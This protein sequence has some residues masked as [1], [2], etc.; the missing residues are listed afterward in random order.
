MIKEGDKEIYKGRWWVPNTQKK[1]FGVLTIIPNKEI[2]LELEGNLEL[3]SKD[4][5]ILYDYLPIEEIILG[6]TNCGRKITLY[7]CNILKLINE[8]HIFP[9]LAIIDWHF[10]SKEQIKFKWINIKLT[11]LDDWANIPLIS[12]QL[13]ETNGHRE[14]IIKIVECVPLNIKIKNFF[15]LKINFGYNA[16]L[17]PIN[18]REINVKR[19]TNISIESFKLIN[20]E[21]SLN[22]IK[23]IRNF[24]ILATL[25]F[26]YLT[27]MKVFYEESK[28]SKRELTIYS[29]SDIPDE[30]EELKYYDMLFT[31][32]DIKENINEILNNWF[33]KA[34][35][36]E[37]IFELYS[38]LLH[39]KEMSYR[40][41]FLIMVGILEQFHR[42]TMEK[43][44]ITEL[45]HK[46]RVDF[47]VD[48][49][50][51]NDESKRYKNWLK[52]IL[53]NYSN[54]KN[55]RK[56]LKELLK[57]SNDVFNLNSRE[58]DSLIY[59]VVETRNYYVH[60][61][62][63]KKHLAAKGMDLFIL[64]KKLE[65][66]FIVTVLKELNFDN[67]LI[68]TIREKGLLGKILTNFWKN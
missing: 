44:D 56:K 49:I 36:F 24:L 15:N 66:I 12:S 68:K 26:I 50:P 21:E 23:K 5:M 65:S 16:P 22:L 18:Q 60:L 54:E 52:E 57:K 3:S 47:I 20:I 25:N 53:E 2:K 29:L 31:L 19:Q 40:N 32:K 67:N 30:I 1:V 13:N 6:D 64:Q 35:D 9:N 63:A 59:K 51:D 10:D 48:S 41:S 4:K 34:E 61:D 43:L 7:N 11:H 33:A 62:D 45:E 27:Q 37:V 55:L 42:K 38:I 14:I 28:N 46:K 39:S 8:M 58:M 17:F